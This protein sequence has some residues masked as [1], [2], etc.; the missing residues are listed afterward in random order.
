MSDEELEEAENQFFAEVRAKKAKITFS[1]DKNFAKN[2]AGRCLECSYLC[3]KCVEVCPNRANVAIDVRD[4][5][6]FE[7][8]YQIVHLD[9]YCNE[10]GNCETF[11]PHDGGPYK[12]KFTIFSSLQDFENS[13]NSGFVLNEDG[14]E[15]RLDS[16]VL[17]SSIEEDGTLDA[18]ISDE[19]KAIIEKVF[20]QYSYLL[21]PVED[22]EGF[23]EYFN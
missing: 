2:E 20:E 11:C 13:Q 5:G 8:P 21:G 23:D 9:A 14:V 3:N 22:Q 6:L 1:Q 18:D 15:I 10:C 12:K 7:H 16:K 4:T 19:I 17:H